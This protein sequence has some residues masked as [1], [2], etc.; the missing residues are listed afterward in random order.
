MK[1]K[2]LFLLI[3]VFSISSFSYSQFDKMMLT[4]GFGVN[5]PK[6]E[7]RGEAFSDQIVTSHGYSHYVTNVS[8]EFLTKN[9]GASTGL[10][11]F[12]AAKINFDKFNTFRGVL[13]LSY[14]NFNTFK[15]DRSANT[16]GLIGTIGGAVDTIIVPV[17]YSNSFNNIGLGFG[18]EI[19]PT[20]F[21]NIIS[22]FFGGSFNMNFL[23]AEITKT[24]S[25]YDSLRANFTSFR[26][27]LNVNMGIEFKVSQMIGVLF[28]WKYDF[29]NLLFKR[30]AGSYT[31]AVQFGRDNLELN[32]EEGIYYSSLTQPVYSTIPFPKA[33][34][35]KHMEWWTVYAG[36][37]LYLNSMTPAPKK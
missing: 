33:A 27:G 1:I 2:L 19:A 25:A 3:F 37:N 17:V 35:Q 32:D 7:M 29:A 12:G 5:E 21:S 6:R 18:L 14:N 30:T 11:F 20:A 28:G 24:L 4:I 10:N 16:L 15:G 31:S 26:M 13:S 9:Y 22:P 8:E 34:Q 36:I 23:S